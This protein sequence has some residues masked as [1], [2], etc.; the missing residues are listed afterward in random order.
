[1]GRHRAIKQY[2]PADRAGQPLDLFTGRATRTPV[3]LELLR[4]PWI[5]R[6]SQLVSGP[7]GSGKRREEPIEVVWDGSKRAPAAFEWN[8]TRYRVDALVQT[9]S[10]ERA[11]W[12]P[13]ARMSRR[14]FRVLARGGLYDLAFDRH[15]GRW[16]LVGVV[17]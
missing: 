10:V 12:D 2:R 15:E 5:V 9:W 17:D 8:G 13:R 11:W 16:L 4:S 6:G 1:M 3:I 14:C 7:L